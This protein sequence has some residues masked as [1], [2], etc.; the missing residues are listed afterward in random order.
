MY[1]IQQLK[2]Q[3]LCCLLN[4]LHW[5]NALSNTMHVEIQH[6]ETS[7]A[8]DWNVHH[9][10][11][12][13]N[14]HSPKENQEQPKRC[15]W[16]VTLFIDVTKMHLKRLQHSIW[17]TNRAQSIQP[18]CQYFDYYTP[19]LKN[20]PTHSFHHQSLQ[21]EAWKNIYTQNLRFVLLKV[22]I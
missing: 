22:V 5:I 4:R 11:F 7:P 20:K 18:H 2:Q 19:L 15:H 1:C 17:N 6:W 8:L 9:S 12:C 21:H 16:E 3:V 13:S 10:C 14:C